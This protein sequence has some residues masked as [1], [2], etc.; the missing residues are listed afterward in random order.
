MDFVGCPEA[1]PVPLRIIAASEFLM[2]AADRALGM[3]FIITAVE[4]MQLELERPVI[5]RTSDRTVL[6]ELLH[7]LMRVFC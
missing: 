1:K 6:P 4:F 3:Q 2:Y 7:D 5:V